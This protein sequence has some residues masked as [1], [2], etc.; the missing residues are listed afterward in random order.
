M[1]INQY[2]SYAEK[3]K[4]RNDR[5]LEKYLR[6]KE[7]ASTPAAARL[8]PDALPR[9][10]NYSSVHENLLIEM[11]DAAVECE[12]TWRKYC[13]FNKHLEKNLAK[14]DCSESLALEIIYIWNQGKPP[15]R[16]RSG[17]CRWCN[18]R[19]KA[20]AAVLIRQA[21]QHLTEILVAQGIPIE[22]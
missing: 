12:E 22:N 20:E 15:E 1:T 8:D 5:A 16:R 2:L 17:V 11:A 4:I 6:L 21:K 14:L 10:R 9:T 7:R 13:S 19:T 18:C 3:L